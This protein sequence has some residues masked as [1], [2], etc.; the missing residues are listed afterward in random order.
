MG[1]SFVDTDSDGVLDT[2]VKDSPRIGAFKRTVGVVSRS[3]LPSVGPVDNAPTSNFGISMADSGDLTLSDY[4]T[5][6]DGDTFTYVVSSSD[7]DVAT[8][9]E[10]GGVLTVTKGAVY[11]TATTVSYTHL[12]LPTKR[13]V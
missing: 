1:A 9:S 2:V 12:T 5:D 6:A 10:T 7:T 11:G 8:V 13:I 3:Y 4:F